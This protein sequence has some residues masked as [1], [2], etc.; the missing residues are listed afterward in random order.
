METQEYLWPIIERSTFL[1]MTPKGLKRTTSE[2][3]IT[4]HAATENDALKAA[5]RSY[6]ILKSPFDNEKR[7]YKSHNINTL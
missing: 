5:R 7:T 1:L 6:R 3:I 4:R 2:N